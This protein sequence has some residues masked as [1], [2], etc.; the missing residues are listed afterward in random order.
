[1]DR[2]KESRSRLSKLRIFFFALVVTLF[3]TA[4]AKAEPQGD[5]LVDLY[6]WNDTAVR[7]LTDPDTIQAM[8]DLGWCGYMSEKFDFPV[9]GFIETSLPGPG[10]TRYYFLRVPNFGHVWVHQ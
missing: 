6:C 7:S 10:D 1:M 8:Q 5:R 3:V 9:W 4:L 2:W